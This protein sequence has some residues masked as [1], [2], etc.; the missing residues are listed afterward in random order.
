M[1]A[2]F[3]GMSNFFKVKR[4]FFNK[5]LLFLLGKRII[6]IEMTGYFYGKSVFL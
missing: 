6:F 5:K 2:L 3:K 1:M 4:N